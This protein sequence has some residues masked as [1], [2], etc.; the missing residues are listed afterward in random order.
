MDTVKRVAISFFKSVWKHILW[1]G[2]VIAILRA[3]GVMDEFV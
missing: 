2:I 1:I 3:S